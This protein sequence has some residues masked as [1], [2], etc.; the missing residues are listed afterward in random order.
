MSAWRARFRRFLPRRFLRSGT[1]H[2]LHDV[3][4]PELGNRREV[5]VYL[6]PTYGGSRRF[7]VV[8]MQDGQNLFDP[9]TA[10]AGDWG[11]LRAL[12]ALA[13]AG[14][15]TIIV[16]VSNAGEARIA[17]YSPFRDE[18]T[19]GGRGD[20]YLAFLIET[21]KPMIDRR[22][23]T[24]PERAHTGIAG[25]SM[26]GLISLYG[27]FRAPAAFGFAGALSPSLW[28]ADGAIFPVIASAPF[29]PG[30]MYVDVARR[31]GDQHVTNVRRF[32]DLMIAKG[33]HAG[34]DFLI[35]EDPDG[36]H[37]EASWGR[38]FP[39]ALAFLLSDRGASESRASLLA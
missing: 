17:E 19:G 32:R 36:G 3:W 28:F 8:Y 26:G 38:R 24:R 34:R 14:H 33:Y 9:A 31:E 30:R 4:S 11:L 7:P 1:L 18:K 39:T 23:R 35:V 25:S 27:F 6:P 20:L 5:V 16:G 29:V 10:H 21:L 13:A 37:D 12:D 2:A 15:E 22:F